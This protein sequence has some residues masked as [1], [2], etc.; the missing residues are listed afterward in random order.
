MEDDASIDRRPGGGFAINALVDPLSSTQGN[1]ASCNQGTAGNL[2]LI[3]NP[4][5]HRETFRAERSPPTPSP[6]DADGN[7]RTNDE[8]APAG[9]SAARNLQSD[10]HGFYGQSAV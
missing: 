7:P 1:L 9:Q 3:R 8:P 10:V 2:P 5:H 6:V 4:S